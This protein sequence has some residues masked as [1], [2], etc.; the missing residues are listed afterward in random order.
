MCIFQKNPLSLSLNESL[1]LTMNES[2]NLEVLAQN[3]TRHKMAQPYWGARGLRFGWVKVQYMSRLSTKIHNPRATWSRF[4]NC[5]IFCQKLYFH[6]SRA[7]CQGR[8][9][10]SGGWS[11]SREWAWWWW[12]PTWWSRARGSV[13]ST[14]QR[15]GPPCLAWSRSQW[16]LRASRPTVQSG[17]IMIMIINTQNSARPLN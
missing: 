5:A 3:G 1:I 4:E 7:R 17:M 14:G 11:G 12:S 8:C 16:L 6:F 10:S 2:I 15:P 9:Q 13:S